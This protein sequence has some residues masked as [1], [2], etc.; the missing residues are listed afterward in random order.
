VGSNISRSMKDVI[1]TAMKQ[2]SHKYKTALRFQ[3]IIEGKVF[4]H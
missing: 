2:S 1:D 4:K 3:L